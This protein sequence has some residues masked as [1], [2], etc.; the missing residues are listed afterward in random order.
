MGPCLKLREFHAWRA[1]TLAGLWV[2]RDEA[3]LSVQT[4]SCPGSVSRT[5]Y[6]KTSSLPDH[7]S[8]WHVSHRLKHSFIQYTFIKSCDAASVVPRAEDKQGTKRRNFPLG[9]FHVHVGQV[10]ISVVRVL[11]SGADGENNTGLQR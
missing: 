5:F 9:S 7:L 2:A 1:D 10:E 3:Q 8:R 6:R 11:S 4:S